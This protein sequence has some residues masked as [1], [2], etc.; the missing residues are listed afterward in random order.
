MLT[1]KALSLKG[2]F[3][4]YSA[5]HNKR[6]MFTLQKLLTHRDPLMTQRYAHLRDDVL[7]RA[8]NLAGDLIKES[9]KE[10]GKIQAK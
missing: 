5:A 8:A 6:A 4:F 2:F 9:V 7:K 3:A 1:T 10:N